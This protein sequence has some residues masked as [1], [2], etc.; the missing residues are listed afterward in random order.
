[1]AKIDK[2]ELKR[3]IAAM[4]NRKFASPPGGSD[5]R[6]PPPSTNR[7]AITKMVE[8]VMKKAGL[9]LSKINQMLAED[10]KA[11]RGVFDKQQAAAARHFRAADAAFRSGMAARLKALS[12]LATPFTSS[13]V[14]LDKPFLIWQLP[15]PDLHIFIDSHVESMNSS[16]RVLVNVIRGF[17]ETHFVFFFLWENESERSAVVNV[18]S[19]LVVNGACSVQAVAGIYAGHTATLELAASLRLVRW[20]GWGTDPVTGAS[21]DQ[22]F[23]QN[24]QQGDGQAVASLQAKGGHIFESA[25]F[26]SQ[27]FSFQP[28]PL[29]H[30]LF[31]IPAKAVVIFEVALDLF[32]NFDGGGDIQD[33]VFV[34]FSNNGNAVVCPNVELEILIPLANGVGA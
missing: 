30:N 24:F 18:A 13:F 6:R 28:F 1:M 20:S 26:K 27:S 25:D 12:L 5:S 2:S 9:D 3:V 31:V 17:D 11:L 29:S 7:R 14:T 23:D 15:R 19:S 16:V 22:T 4:K 8:S 33:S 21:N 32:Y 10:Q 34:D